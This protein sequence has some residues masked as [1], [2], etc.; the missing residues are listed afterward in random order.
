MVV[1]NGYYLR[2][3]IV[4]L[5][6]GFIPERGLA[7]F[8]QFGKNMPHKIYVAASIGARPKKIDPR[9]RTIFFFYIKYLKTLLTT[10]FYA[11]AFTVAR[12]V[13]K[14]RPSVNKL[15]SFSHGAV[16]T[17][18]KF[19]YRFGNPL[20][21][22]PFLERGPPEIAEGGPFDPHWPISRINPEK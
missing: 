9:I 5:K 6:A 7:R 4:F 13:P 1:I 10:S 2:Y 15:N 18:I 8:L 14:W 12:N 17:N 3:K 21:W 11:H 22:A 19:K 20:S 16:C